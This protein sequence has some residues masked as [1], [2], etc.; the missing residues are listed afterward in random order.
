MTIRVFDSTDPPPTGTACR[1]CKDAGH[2]CPAKGYLSDVAVC[3]ACG[4]D[5][6]CERTLVITKRH[7]VEPSE[8]AS[9]V[10]SSKPERR[11]TDCRGKLGEQAIGTMCWP[12]RRLR[13]QEAQ[14]EAK[15]AASAI[16]EKKRFYPPNRRKKVA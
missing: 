1:L 9:K 12:C 5:K 3:I 2:F 7:T 13:K 15:R 8:Y 10:T 4:E 11:C 14:R 6:P 16:R